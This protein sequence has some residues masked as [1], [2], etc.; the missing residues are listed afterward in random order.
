MPRL[1]YSLLAVAGI[2]LLAV[3]LSVIGPSRN[4][5][6]FSLEHLFT[7]P[8]CPDHYLRASCGYTLIARLVSQR[9]PL[10]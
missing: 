6:Q 3:V 9:I 5:S 7:K 8:L 2:V 4:P 10:S 1:K